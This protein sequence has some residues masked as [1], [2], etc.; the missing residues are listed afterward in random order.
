MTQGSQSFRCMA[1]PSQRLSFTAL[2]T[3]KREGARPGSGVHQFHP[4]FI[5]QS[6]VIWPVYMQGRLGNVVS[7]GSGEGNDI[8]EHLASLYH[9]YIISLTFP[10][11][12]MDLV[13]LLSL[14]VKEKS[15]VQGGSLTSSGKW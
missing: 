15:E 3:G 1:P 13:S 5:G 11:N 9:M 14:L 2:R 10:E 7:L 4:N 6:S 8:D 12:P